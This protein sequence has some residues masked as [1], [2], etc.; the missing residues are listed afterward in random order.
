MT[1]DVKPAAF[2]RIKP[3]AMAKDVNRL[4]ARQVAAFDNAGRFKTSAQFRRRRALFVKIGYASVQQCFGFGMFGVMTVASGNNFEHNTL[5]ACRVKSIF[6]EVARQ[7]GSTT[8]IGNF[9]RLDF[10]GDGGNNFFTVKHPGLDRGDIENNRIPPQ[11]D[12]GPFRL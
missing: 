1:S 5:K 8:T 2:E 4:L 9:R 6:P 7:T 10:V 11:F 12:A 3:I